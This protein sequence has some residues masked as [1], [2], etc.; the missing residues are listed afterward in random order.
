MGG[1]REWVGGCVS[2][3][4][5]YHTIYMPCVF[6]STTLLPSNIFCSQNFLL[7]VPCLPATTTL[8]T[9][10]ST[11]Y[12]KI[13]PFWVET[14]GTFPSRLGFVL[15]GAFP[16][17]TILLSRFQFSLHSRAFSYTYHY[18]SHSYIF[19]IPLSGLEE[20]FINPFIISYFI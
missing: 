8:P 15:P 17:P 1:D 10:L 18:T 6:R 11:Y 4:V 19:P 2:P 7:G 3:C 5:P 13:L 12:P 14:V 20:T 9:K 16:S